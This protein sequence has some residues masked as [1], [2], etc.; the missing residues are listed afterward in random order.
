M[1]TDKLEQ[2]GAERWEI[3]QEVMAHFARMGI[4]LADVKPGNIMFA[5]PSGDS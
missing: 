2:F 4:F 1:R 3:V 5:E